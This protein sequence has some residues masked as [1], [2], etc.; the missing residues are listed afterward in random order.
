[1]FDQVT[2]VVHGTPNEDKMKNAEHLFRN[3]A[4]PEMN[5][6]GRKPAVRGLSMEL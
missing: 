2:T 3:K 4:H 6:L 1:M 5:A